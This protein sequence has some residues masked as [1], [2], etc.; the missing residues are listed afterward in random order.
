MSP[1]NLQL[2]I[3]LQHEIIIVPS[4]AFPLGRTSLP[5]INNHPS[6]GVLAQDEQL[7]LR[8]FCWRQLVA[9]KLCGS[10]KSPHFSSAARRGARSDF[11]TAVEPSVE[12]NCCE[13]NETTQDTKSGLFNDI[14]GY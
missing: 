4:R 5:L 1:L 11:S 9:R 8:C 7:Y 10:I 3:T 6:A 2:H 14:T 13:R 12:K